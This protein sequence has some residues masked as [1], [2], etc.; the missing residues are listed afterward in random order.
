MQNNAERNSITISIF[1]DHINLTR[2]TEDGAVDF[3]EV[4]DDVVI[5]ESAIFYEN[6]EM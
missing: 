4:P 2:P 1:R 3:R 6:N 5:I